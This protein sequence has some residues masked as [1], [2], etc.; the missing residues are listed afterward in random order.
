[1]EDTSI[2][3]E[4][5]EDQLTVDTEADV[6]DVTS[7]I[8]SSLSEATED[9]SPPV[10]VSS[11]HSVKRPRVQKPS[12]KSAE[13]NIEM[14]KLSLLQQVQKTL[15][16]SDADSEE[17]FGQQVASELRNIKNPALQL[18]LRRNIMNLIYDVQ[19]TA[20]SEQGSLPEN[21]HDSQSQFPGTQVRLP[22]YP[23]RPY[24]VQPAPQSHHATTQPNS[25]L[26]MLNNA[27]Q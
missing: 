3:E 27:Q 9:P 18:R 24:Q 10:Q 12:A 20:F 7:N 5:E 23:M 21:L 11:G 13:H 19:E 16:A 2:T 25:F 22:L 26:S 4:G 8:S 15:S 17:R 14:V 1:M 6:E